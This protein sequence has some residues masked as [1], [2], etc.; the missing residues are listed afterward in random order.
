MSAADG[1]GILNHITGVD[2]S[3]ARFTG[4]G[5]AKASIRG[6]GNSTGSTLFYMPIGSVY[7]NFRYRN[8]SGVRFVIVKKFS[9]DL[10]RYS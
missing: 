6:T 4:M 9:T 2:F 5:N 1:Y 10:Y 3:V 7:L 8:P